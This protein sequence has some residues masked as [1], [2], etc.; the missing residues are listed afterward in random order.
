MQLP[1]CSSL[2]PA[3]IAPTLDSSNVQFRFAAQSMPS[4]IW[5]H[6]TSTA[7][8]CSMSAAN[9]LLLSTPGAKVAT[10]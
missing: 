2:A 3:N 8:D 10:K 6:C 9:W 4:A 1:T 7:N 5:L